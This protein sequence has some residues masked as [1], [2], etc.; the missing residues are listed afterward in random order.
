MLSRSTGW[1][2]DWLDSVD[3]R[4]WWRRRP[5][6][7]SRPVFGDV[8]INK[9]NRTVFICWVNSDSETTGRCNVTYRMR[10]SPPPAGTFMA[11]RHRL[12]L[13]FE[14][15]SSHHPKFGL[16]KTTI[17]FSIKIAWHQIRVNNIV[18]YSSSRLLLAPL[19]H[20]TCVFPLISED[21]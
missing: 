21:A 11:R 9:D 4:R 15:W 8:T 13:R 10:P 7:V 19:S 2:P 6:A 5:P 1:L 12:F 3:D 18:F 17:A 20:A 16:F 14:M